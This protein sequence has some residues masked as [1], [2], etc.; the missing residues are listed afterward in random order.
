[1][2]TC[3]VCNNQTARYLQVKNQEVIHLCI[4][5]VKNAQGGIVKDFW[6]TQSDFE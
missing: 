1:M 2:I 4:D 3:K 6:T 5:C